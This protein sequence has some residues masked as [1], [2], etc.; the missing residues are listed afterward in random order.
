PAFAIALGALLVDRRVPFKHSLAFATHF[1]TFALIWLCALFPTVAIVLALV[2]LSAPALP[3][4]YSMDVVVSALEAGVLGWYLYEALKTV[5]GLSR[6]RRSITSV[7]LIA[8]LFVI[9]KAY[10]L[11]VFAVT[12]YST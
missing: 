8:A 2:A 11:V 5:Y 10:H 7:A 1:F 3:S 12:L 4:P 6:L 9:L